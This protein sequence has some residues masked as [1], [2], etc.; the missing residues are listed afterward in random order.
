MPRQLTKR[1]HRLVFSNGILA[2]AGT[3][4]VVILATSGKVDRLIPL[5]A[6]G[7]FT[8]FTMSQTGMARYHLRHKEDGWRTGLF[9]NGFGALLTFVVDVIIA[10]TKFTHGAWVIIVI[11]PILVAVLLR[12]NKQYTEEADE[13]LEDAAR[14]AEAPILRRHVVLV[15]IDTIDLASARAL[16]YARTLAPDEMRA[17]H[18]AVDMAR[19]KALRDQWLELG[20]SRI[21]LEIVACPDRRIQ[22]AGVE[23]VAE[24]LADGK[25]EV[26]V[27]LPRIQRQRIWHKL[28]HDRT[29]DSLASEIAD[30]PHANVTFVPYHLGRRHT[31]EIVTREVADLVVPELPVDRRDDG[32]TPISEARHRQQV[33]LAGTVHAIRIQPRGGIATMECRL[34]DASGEIGI[35]FLGRRHIA[36]VEPDCVITVT[37]AVGSRR[38]NLEI[39]NPYYTLAPPAEAPAP[40]RA[41]RSKA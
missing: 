22:R 24:V 41:R 20:F 18:F 32:V 15:F 10:V 35:V 7:V 29:A 8:S 40:A 36:G 33:T 17:V 31:R 26:S 9:I 27:L 2:L 19:A 23:M 12:L 1:G 16:Q 28:L 37:G 25:T 4:I 3:S 13:L 39:V 11:V 38:G 14:A 30:L 21:T 34:R 6:V 5:Y